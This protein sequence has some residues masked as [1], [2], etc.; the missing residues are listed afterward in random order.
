MESK[1]PVY[2]THLSSAD[3]VFR[4][5][6]SRIELQPLMLRANHFEALVRS[7]IS[8]QISTKAAQSIAAKFV[9]LYRGKFPSPKQVLKTPNE[10]LRGV[11]LSQS[12][13]VYIKNLADFAVTHKD[14][15]RLAELQNEEVIELLTQVKGIGRWTAEM[16]LIFALGRED[17]FSHGDNGLKSAIKKLYRLRKDP[18]RAT[19]ERISKV[20]K[21]YRSHASR[22]LWASLDNQ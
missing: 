22:Y 2:I 20:W 3:L 7:I 12:K 19:L 17:V 1:N 16:F 15:N 8:Q 11:G 18:S 5:L 21:P 6:V 9:K 13:V 14:F 4:Q 10:V